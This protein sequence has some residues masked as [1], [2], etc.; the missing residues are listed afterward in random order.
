VERALVQRANAAGNANEREVAT[1]H[2]SRSC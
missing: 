2:Y 1:G